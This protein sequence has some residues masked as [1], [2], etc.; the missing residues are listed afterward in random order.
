MCQDRL[1]NHTRLE[2]SIFWVAGKNDRR[3]LLQLR[4]LDL[5]KCNMSVSIFN[6]VIGPVIRGRRVRIARLRGAL[7]GWR[8]L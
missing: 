2:G 8:A 6:D 4:V 5:S 1:A 7:A 3:F